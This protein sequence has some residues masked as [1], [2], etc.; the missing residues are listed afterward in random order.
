MTQVSIDSETNEMLK[1]RCGEDFAAKLSQNIEI[2]A[3]EVARKGEGRGKRRPR[4]EKRGERKQRE[5]K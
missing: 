3:H 2:K 1:R 5:P 4:D